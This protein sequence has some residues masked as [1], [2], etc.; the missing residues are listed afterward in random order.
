MFTLR[1][2]SETEVKTDTPIMH[3][4]TVFSSPFL[5]IIIKHCIDSG[6]TFKPDTSLYGG[7]YVDKQGDCYFIY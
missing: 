6:Y 5:S 1:K 7:Y 4:P 2:L 3:L